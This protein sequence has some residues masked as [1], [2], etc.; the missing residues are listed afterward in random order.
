MAARTP[1]D[2]TGPGTGDQGPATA[3]VR[4]PRSR[5]R[6]PPRAS[7]GVSVF[8]RFRFLV[9]PSAGAVPPPPSSPPESSPATW[10]Q[11]AWHARRSVRARCDDVRRQ[12]VYQRRP[13]LLYAA[14]DEMVPSRPPP[15]P[16][17][18][19]SSALCGP[20]DTPIADFEL[21]IVN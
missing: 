5:F 7:V 11:M 20:S 14:R 15:A 12:T 2:T 21:T 13:G 6:A 1:R 8:P 18:A 3:G 17:V 4:V 9:N 16:P 19:S 10:S